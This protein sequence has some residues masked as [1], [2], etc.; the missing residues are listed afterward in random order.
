MPNT[1]LADRIDQE[2]KEELA[3]QQQH[4]WLCHSGAGRRSRPG[5][6]QAEADPGP[7]D[8][9]F[10]PSP[11]CKIPGS[12]ILEPRLTPFL[13]AHLTTD[14]F[15]GLKPPG[16][17]TTLYGMG[18]I[19]VLIL[20]VACFNFMN[21]ATARATM[22]AREISL[23]KC[24]GARRGQLIVQFL[25]ESVLMALMALVI[26]LALVE[27]LLPA[28][29]RFMG[30]PLSFHYLADWPLTLAILAVGILAGLLSGLYPALVLSGFRPAATLRANTSGQAA[31]AGC[32]PRW[33]CCS[34]RSRSAWAS[35]PWSCSSR[36]SSPATSIWASAAT[37]SSSPARRPPDRGR[38]SRAS[39]RRWSAGPAFSGGPHQLHALQRQ[40]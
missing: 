8:R 29:S 35:A 14:R 36:S 40:Q 9:H 31:R 22:R 17:W 15:G 39:C 33:W 18:V 5:H 26:A 20:L 23:R 30:R 34:S 13:D 21:L 27:V 10:A 37:I 6:G 4:L 24:M 12:Q 16:S 38:A 2:Q 11:T 25:G 19:G 3:Q 32:A 28:Y 1:S 7:F